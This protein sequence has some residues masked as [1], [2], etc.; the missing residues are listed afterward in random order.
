MSA[1]ILV[2]ALIFALTP[3]AAAASNVP[4]PPTPYITN[5]V[6]AWFPNV[7]PAFATW[8]VKLT[9]YHYKGEPAVTAYTANTAAIADGAG[10]VAV[11]VPMD[12]LAYG[13][14]GGYDSPVYE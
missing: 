6:T 9:A 11:T 4:A 8:S 13:Y 7:G 12:V 5:D 1:R 3:P 14:E 10:T 2:A